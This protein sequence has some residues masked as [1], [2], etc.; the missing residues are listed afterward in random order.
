MTI[1]SIFAWTRGLAH[2]A[3]LDDNTELAKFATTLEEVCV[4]TVEGGEMT[5][6]LAILISK[7]APFLT[8]EDFLDA[9]D[10]RL[11]A[12]MDA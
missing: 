9:L 8:T 11:K 4:E 12:K 1:G 5:K 2:R 7:D 6:D 10:R 3:K